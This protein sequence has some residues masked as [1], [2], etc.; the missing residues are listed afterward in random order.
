MHGRRKS[1]R[2]RLVV[3]L[4]IVALLGL[5]LSACGTP[6]SPEA[7][8]PPEA[9]TP[10]EPEPTTPS[11]P[12]IK[13]GGTLKIG[14]ELDWENLDP[15]QYLAFA[16]TA[17]YDMVYEG[18]TTWDLET[19]EPKPLLAKSWEISDDGLTYTFHLQE[20][21]KWHNGDDFTAEDVKYSIERIQDPATGSIQSAQLAIIES[22][23]VVDDL[24]VVLHLSAPYSPL[25]AL[26]PYNPY[27]VNKE[28]IEAE[29]GLTPRTM[30]GTGPFMLEEW[31]PDTV[32]R[33]VRNPDYWRKGADGQPLPYLDAIEFYPMVDDTARVAD[34]LSGVVD[35]I[36]RVPEQDMDRLETTEGIQLSAP[37]S[38][39]Y[40]YL[41]FDP[42]KPPFDDARVREAVAWAIDRDQL[43]QAALYGRAFPLYGAAIPSWHWAYSD[44]REYDHRDVDKSRAL[45]A[46][47][48]YPNGFDTT[49]V[50]TSDYGIAVALAEMIVPMLEEVGINA[51]LELYD[52]ATFFENMGGGKNVCQYQFML[53]GETPSGDPDDTYYIMHYS[54]GDWNYCGYANP[55]IDRLLEEGRAVS[56]PVQ[57]K[58]IYRQLETTL[59]EELPLTYLA[60]HHH[61]EAYW[62]Y[63]Q[64]YTHMGNNRY[65]AFFYTW[66]DK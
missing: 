18:L 22:V 50:T 37:W 17:A 11:T 27:I 38:T 63:V 19:L 56:D 13:R 21:V 1:M 35:F 49:L 33:M 53:C 20:D 29:G 32:T 14:Y 39:T 23:E 6:A 61:D 65:R 45:L 52:A 41:W 42:Y 47:A 62:D 10:S 4:S 26:L 46:E 43:V 8:T 9:A 55:E 3:L 31:V 64:G 57:R 59:L 7:T 28:F 51:T 25:L 5:V 44:I 48:G 30:M 12:E 40:T 16:D 34:L 2:A 24:T 60:L 58:E 54:T 66:L 36:V 15:S